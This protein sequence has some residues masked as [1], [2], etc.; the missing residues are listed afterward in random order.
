M[1]SAR[2]SEPSTKG[3]QLS[4]GSVENIVS[5]FA[6]EVQD[7]DVSFLPA[8]W[9]SVKGRREVLRPP[10]LPDFNLVSE[11]AF[12]TVLPERPCERDLIVSAYEIFAGQELGQRAPAAEAEAELVSAGFGWPGMLGGSARGLSWFTPALRLVL[13]ASRVP[14]FK[15]VADDEESTFTA[16]DHEVTLQV[17]PRGVYSNFHKAWRQ[18]SVEPDD[19]KQSRMR[20]PPAV[21]V[22]V[23][24]NRLAQVAKT[25]KAKVCLRLLGF[26]H[27]TRC[28]DQVWLEDT[29]EQAL[30]RRARR[31]WLLG[32]PVGAT[33][34][35]NPTHAVV[36]AAVAEL[37]RQEP[38]V[39][40]RLF[41]ILVPHLFTNSEFRRT[42]GP[43]ED[44]RRVIRQ[45]TI[46]EWI[47]RVM[48]KI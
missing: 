42:F 20:L 14:G 23:M 24:A 11:D 5:T 34:R 41:D 1:L 12:G 19:V 8:V 7:G 45:S 47:N 15:M 9:L 2:P 46:E 13:L 37:Y 17:S 36:D 48:A 27:Q 39:M 33:D 29:M 44:A 26:V 10:Q 18:A 22:G 32:A 43:P 3:Q 28:A 25:H 4:Q 31:R 38:G 21:P 6:R 30:A 16:Y 35:I 40:P